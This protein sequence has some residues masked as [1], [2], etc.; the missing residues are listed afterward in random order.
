MLLDQFSSSPLLRNR[1]EEERKSGIERG[2]TKRREH[3]NRLKIRVQS[4]G[5]TIA[6]QIVRRKVENEIAHIWVG[7]VPAEFVAK[8]ESVNM[9]H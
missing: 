3:R 9:A 7:H 4:T 5:D 2:G 8:M 1:L 6:E